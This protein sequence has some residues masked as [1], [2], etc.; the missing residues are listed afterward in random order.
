MIRQIIQWK[1]AVAACGMLLWCIAAV[2]AHTPLLTIED[3]GDGTLFIQGGFSNGASAGGVKLYLTSVVTNEKL[4]EGVFPDIGELEVA[5]PAEPY[6]V[7]FDAGPGH[8]V[9]KDGPPPPGG[10]GAPQSEA[11]PA[12]TGEA[13]AEYTGAG[14]PAAGMDASQLNW[15]AQD[16]AAV[17]PAAGVSYLSIFIALISCANAVMLIILLRRKH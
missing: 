6:T 4:W 11:Q 10:F 5:I 9:V 14:Q 1:K 12:H 2:F 16:T 3:N 15:T 13:A 7:T 8:V 17:M